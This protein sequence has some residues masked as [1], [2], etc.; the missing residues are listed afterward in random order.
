LKIPGVDSKEIQEREVE[1]GRENEKI[2]V[3]TYRELDVKIEVKKRSVGL[4][5]WCWP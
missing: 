1:S 4:N 2:E 5:P 3:E